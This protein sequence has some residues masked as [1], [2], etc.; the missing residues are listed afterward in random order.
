MSTYDKASLV[1]I[2]SGTKEG[3]IF[4]LKPTNGDGDFTFSRSTAATRVNADGL[5][6][7]ETQNLLLQSNSFDTTWASTD[8]LTSGQS[9]Y[10]GSNNA[11]LF[12]YAT[13][14][15][16][17]IQANTNGGV[18]TYS[19]YAKGSASNGIRLY[20][21]GSTNVN[22]YFNLN[23]GTVGAESNNINASIEDVGSG[24]YRCSM[25]YNSTN[26][27]LYLYITNNANA[28]ATSGSIYIQD[29]QLEEGLV[30]R[31]YIETTTTAVYGGITDN[32]PRLDYTVAADLTG[33]NNVG[34]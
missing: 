5:I 34:K 26:T 14:N 29:A 6:E 24:W 16:I 32:V 33:S 13:N 4:S 3:T 23:T 31:D 19:V 12:T 9:G 22:V 20:A 28:N 27:N 7:K 17:A 2:P 8:G 30:A 25:T 11:W 15:A 1:L 18:Q 21:F 10:D